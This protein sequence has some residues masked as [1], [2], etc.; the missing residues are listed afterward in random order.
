MLRDMFLGSIAEID[1][2][3][4]SAMGIIELESQSDIQAILN[5]SP[6]ELKYGKCILLQWSTCFSIVEETK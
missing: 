4:F 3:T 6:I 1:A 2:K 5:A